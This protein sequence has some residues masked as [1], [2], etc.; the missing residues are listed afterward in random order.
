MVSIDSGIK[1]KAAKIVKNRKAIL[2]KLIIEF[3]NC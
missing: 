3:G 2:F 1:L